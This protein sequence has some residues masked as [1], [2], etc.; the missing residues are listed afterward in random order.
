MR[1]HMAQ[2]RLMLAQS[3]DSDSSPALISSCLIKVHCGLLNL[4]APCRP[5]LR[6]PRAASPGPTLP[7][8]LW[9]TIM[10]A[11]QLGAVLC[12]SPVC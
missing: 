12:W 1:G 3:N 8:L 5:V 7:P 10:C 9:P 11:H 4:P 2:Q 6:L